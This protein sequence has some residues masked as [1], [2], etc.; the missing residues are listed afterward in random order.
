MA[1]AKPEPPVAMGAA[2]VGV[3][4]A[5]R[6]DPWCGRARLWVGP[7]IGMTGGWVCGGWM[8]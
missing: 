6:R 1:A 3:V 7:G 4:G 2:G 5:V 8:G